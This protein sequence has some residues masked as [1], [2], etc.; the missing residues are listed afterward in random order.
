MSNIFENFQDSKKKIVEL[1]K[2]ATEFNWITKERAEE[3]IKKINND[4]LTIGV[5]GQMKCGKSTFLNAFVF[6]DEILP[7]A[8]TPMTA[9]LTIITYGPEKKIVAE[10]YTK[11]EWFEQK[12]TASRNLSEVEGNEFETSKI[13]S[14][15]ELVAK[16]AVLGNTLDSLLGKTQTDTFENLEDYVGVEGRYIS[17]TKSVKIYY[18]KEYLKGVEIVDTPGINDP[19]VSREERTKDFLNKADV[20]LMMLYAGRPFD[21]TD[22]TLLFE[23]V[24]KCGTG[25]VLIGINKYDIPYENGETEDDIK[26]YVEEQINES[27]SKYNDD[28]ISSIL[29]E[30][31]TVPLSANMAL[32]SELSSERIN[33]DSDLTEHWNRYCNIFEISSQPQ[34]R[35]KSHIDILSKQ[36]LDLIENEK[37]KILFTKPKNEIQEAGVLKTAELLQKIS[38]TENRI[39]ILQTPDIELDEK[40]ENLSRAKDKMERKLSRLNDNLG[41]LLEEEYLP[42]MKRAIEDLVSNSCNMLSRVVNNWKSS[43]DIEQKRQEF[44]KII[45]RLTTKELPRLIEDDIIKIKKILKDNILEYFKKI[46]D[47]ANDYIDFDSKDYFEALQNKVVLKTEETIDSFD[48]EDIFN[49]NGDLWN[50]LKKGRFFTIDFNRNLVREKIQEFDKKF[51]AAP[52]INFVLLKKDEIV[53]SLNK[54]TIQEILLPIQKNIE[55]CKNNKSD[56]EKQTEEAEKILKTLKSEKTQLEEQIKIIS[57]L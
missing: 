52:F 42:S 31:E 23:N 10:F 37:G 55:E 5:I 56:K 48:I 2:K 33:K 7:V 11:D 49:K 21:L 34:F 44:D 18:P 53:T 30:V 46:A 27:C 8:T 1:T 15:K 16:S 28:T 51:A 40:L 3:I 19:I 6:E 39:K 41:D 36:V 4:I 47:I 25:K 20:V 24:R 57:L 29:Q 50:S 45:S 9:S 38:E 26:K 17:I 32:L 54:E 22:R 14:A 12:T 43:E 13:Q 35:E